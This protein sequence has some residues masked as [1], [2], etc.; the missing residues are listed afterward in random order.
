MIKYLQSFGLMSSGSFEAAAP[1]HRDQDEERAECGV[2][3]VGEDVV[4]V[5]EA[6][7]EVAAEGVVEARVVVVLAS[8]RRRANVRQHHLQ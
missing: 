1:A 6:E 4:E 8:V 2:G 5:G 3:D 7:H